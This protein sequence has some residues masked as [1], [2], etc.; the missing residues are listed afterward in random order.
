VGSGDIRFR[1]SRGGGDMS[2]FDWG[3]YTIGAMVLFMIGGAVVLFIL[4][5]LNDQWEDRRGPGGKDEHV[6]DLPPPWIRRKR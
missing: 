4:A 2:P 1:V 5:W 3:V 6:V